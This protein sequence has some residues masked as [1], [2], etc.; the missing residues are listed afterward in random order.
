MIDF[1]F[2]S[3]DDLI[4]A[5]IQL[6]NPGSVFAFDIISNMEICL[7]MLTMSLLQRWS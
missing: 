7:E 4:I 3:I 6:T 2:Q 5:V 1:K